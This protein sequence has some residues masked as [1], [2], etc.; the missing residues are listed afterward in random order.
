MKIGLT[1]EEFV[2]LRLMP[3]AGADA[4]F[5]QAAEMEHEWLFRMTTARAARQ[6]RWRGYDCK[7]QMRELLVENGVAR[8]RGPGMAWLFI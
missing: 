2:E 6:L 3:L 4:A 8:P 5:R 1:F 7:P